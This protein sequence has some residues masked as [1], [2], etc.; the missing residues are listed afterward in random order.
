MSSI[1]R[2]QNIRRLSTIVASA[3][4]LTQSP[5]LPAIVLSGCLLVRAQAPPVERISLD[6]AIQLALAHNHSLQAAQT[7]VAQSRAQEITARLRPNPL[8]SADDSFIPV[9]SPYVFSLPSSQ[10][11]LPQEFD[12]GVS[13]LI[14]R[15]GKR[16]ARTQAARDQ[17]A[18]VESAVTDAQRRLIANVAQQFIAALL[19]RSNLEFAQQNLA[20]F[21]QTVHLSELRKQAGD[22]SQNDLLRI[23]IQL[24]QFQMDVS[25]AQI[26]HVQALGSLRQ[27]LGFESAPER[28]DVAG[29]LVYIPFQLDKSQLQAMALDHRP[30]LAAS[31]KGVTSAESQYRLAKANAKRDLTVSWQFSHVAGVNSAD[32]G[33]NIE[34]PIFTRNQGE[35]ARTRYAI[36][37]S[38]QLRTATQE[39]VLT[40]VSNAYESLN[41]SAQIMALYQS[42]YLAQA[43]ESM[44][45]SEFAYNHGA[46]SLLDFLDAQRSYRSVQLN[47]RQG[48]A[49]C[50]LALEQLRQAVGNR[51][52]P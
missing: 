28:Y 42:G 13:Y 34:I 49:N 26:S 39:T 52:L 37:Q 51:N 17:T 46:A 33:T 11:P 5:V 44:Q 14:E 24:L 23:K 16:Q 15:G 36:D 8:L 31:T 21:Q 35:I 50:M 29:E 22:I 12:I 48:L 25:A 3:R 20:S 40:E 30:D 4:G 19:A 41:T 9:F 1:R 2:T 32:F 18:V 27:L 7:Q 10:N 6:Q 47:Y 38:Q 43:E 45:I